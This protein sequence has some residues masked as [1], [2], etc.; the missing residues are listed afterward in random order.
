MDLY[1]NRF[2]VLGLL[3]IRWGRNAGITD[4]GA[5]ARL[6]EPDRG[7]P[8]PLLARLRSPAEAAGS[9]CVVEPFLEPFVER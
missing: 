9:I 7:T 4:R 2:S 1:S 3:N 6:R 8:P 5:A